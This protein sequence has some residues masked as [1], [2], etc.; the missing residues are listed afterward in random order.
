MT[1]RKRLQKD[2]GD[3][4]SIN[5]AFGEM[6][7]AAQKRIKASGRKSSLPGMRLRIP[8]EDPEFSYF[9][10]TD[11]TSSSCYHGNMLE[12]GYTYVRHES[13]AHAGEV[14]QDKYK[15]TTMYAMRI[16]LKDYMEIQIEHRKRVDMTEI[17]LRDLE[18]NQY[19]ADESGKGVTQKQETK[20]EFNPLMD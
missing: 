19:A 20:S 6:E 8:N 16:P 13:G 18:K 12:Q 4:E 2:L 14:L 3:R 5:D 9:W 11:L 7:A 1:A 10:A 17:G 15:S